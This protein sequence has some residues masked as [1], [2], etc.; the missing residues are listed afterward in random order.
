MTAGS[1]IIRVIVKIVRKGFL[2][3]RYS[4]NTYTEVQPNIQWK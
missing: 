2:G 3:N 4:K 1:L